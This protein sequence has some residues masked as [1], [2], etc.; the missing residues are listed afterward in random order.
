LV[1][2]CDDDEC[3]YRESVRFKTSQGHLFK[4]VWENVSALEKI[5]LAPKTNTTVKKWSVRKR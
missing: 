1:Y 2:G 4:A 5:M 3:R